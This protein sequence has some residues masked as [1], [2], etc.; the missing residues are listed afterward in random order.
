MVGK[1]KVFKTASVMMLAVFLLVGCTTPPASVGTQE[2][3]TVSQDKGNIFKIGISQIV[4]HPALDASREGFIA[5]L[6]ENGFKQGENVDIEFQ[7]AHGDIATAQTI[8]SSFVANKKDMILAIATPTAQAAY[9]KTKDIPILITAVTDPMDAGLVKSWEKSG[10]NVTGTSDMTPIKKQLE[11]LKQLIPS[12]KKV[13]ILF[14]TSESN[15]EIQIKK[16]K[17]LAPDFSLEIVT[18]GVTNV[19]EI[20]QA[21]QEL[22][23]NVDVI[24]VPTD[25]LVASGMPLIFNESMKRKIPI[26]GSESAHVEAGALAT[27]GI[28]YYKLGFQTGLMA[29]D[30]IKGESPKNMSIDTLKDTQLIINKDTAEK[31]QISISEELKKSAELIKGG[32]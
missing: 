32:E 20:P 27:E 3:K 15:S 6:E 14:N 2:N 12:A 17:E 30:V 11:L 5:A 21:M 1:K 13:G 25:N 22:L 7:N 8:A 31:L 26:I 10:T 4:D 19:N 18:V 24:Y 29:I 23:N 9:N 28:D 16:I